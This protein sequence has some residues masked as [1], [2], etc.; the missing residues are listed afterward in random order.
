M[1]RDGKVLFTKGY[2]YADLEHRVPIT[3]A[4]V[5]DVASVSKQFAGLAV[6]M[7]VDA[8]QVKLTDDIRKY[9]PELAD[10]GHTVTIDHLLHHTS[11]YRDWPGTLASP[12]GA[13]TTS[14]RSTR[15]CTMAYNQR[16][17]N[18]VPG[19]EYTYSNTGYNVLD[20]DGAAGE[21]EVVPRIHRR[22]RSSARSA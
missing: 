7:L 21:R 14:S 11:G 2:G 3:P 12:A 19:A 18:F 9:I 20:G 5:F 4:T 10:V 16:T 13:S 8:G 15:S 6:A 1:V 22:V 17:L